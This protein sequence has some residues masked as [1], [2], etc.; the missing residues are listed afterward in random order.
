MYRVFTEEEKDIILDWLE[1]LSAKPEPCIEPIPDNPAGQPWPEK[2]TQLIANFARV[3]RRAHDKL[4]L[5]DAQGRAVALV[6]LFDDPAEMMQAL[7]RG[8]WVVPGEPERSMF[9]TRI[10]ENG[11][12]MEGVF[13]ADD[14]ETVRQWILAGAA[15][16]KSTGTLLAL[17]SRGVTDGPALTLLDKRP[18][19]GQGGVH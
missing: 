12:P 4:T 11:G 1:S 5:P 15:L 16:P 7:V 10:M 6:D 17:D 19:I 8:G 2:M 3:A 9:L 13:A 14:V 18:F